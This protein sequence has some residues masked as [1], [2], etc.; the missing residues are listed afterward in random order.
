[1]N[2]KRVLTGCLLLGLG[3]AVRAGA[4]TFTLQ[5]AAD[6]SLRVGSANQNHGSDPTLQLSHDGRVLVRFDQGALA[7]TVG[8]G[9]LVSASLE[10][11]VQS[12]SGWGAAGHPIE[13][14][15]LTA[16]WTEAGATWNCA[17]DAN[18]AN[19]K[20]DCAAPW[21]GGTF[22]D[23]ASDT[24]LQTKDTGVWLIFD[25]TADVAA[26]LAGTPNQGWLIE[27]SDG[28][29]SGKAE[30]TS[31]E[32]AAAERPRLVLLVET[33]AND[34]VPPSLA[35][36][37]PNQPVL[38][39]DP[40]P[41]IALAYADGGSGIDLATLQV[42][43]DGQDVTAACVVGPQS[44]TCHAAPIL[45]A[46]N[47]AVQA[48]LRDRAGNAAQASAAFQLLLG[49]GPHVVTLQTVGD[50]DLRGGEADRN[51]GAEPV[52]RVRESGPNRALVQ[53]DASALASTLAGATLVSASLELHIGLN[54]RNWGKTGRPV[55]AHRLTGTW[56]EL[57]ATWDCPND[58]NATNREPDCATPWAGGSFAPA[59][60]ASVLHTR[61]LTGWVTFDVTAD[62]AAF[63]A[64]G[65]DFGWLLKKTDETQ[66]GRVDYDSRE[67]T[68]GDATR[69]V[70]VFTTSS[71]A[72]D[73]TPPAA[74]ITSPGD[75]ALVSSPTVTVTGSASDNVGLASLTVNGLPVTVTNGGFQT[76][77]DLAE[78][79]NTIFAIATD[80]SGLQSTATVAVT[81]DSTPPTLTVDSPRPNQPTNQAMIEVA[82]SATD[83]SGI[84]AVSVNGTPVSLVGDRFDVPVILAEGANTLTVAATDG[85]GNR[86]QAAVVAT[87]FS[88]P[89]VTI[90]SPADLSYLA[91]TTVDVSGTVSDPGAVVTVEGV[92]ATVSGTSF[93]ARD[94][95][96]V[97]GGNTVTAAATNS[98][99]HTA[100]ATINVVRDLTPPYVV[101]Y[102]PQDGST[103]SQPAVAVSGLI[104]DIVPGTVN[105]GQAAVEVN[106]APAAV[107]N[108][109]FL[110]PSLILT[111]GVNVITAVGTDA[112]G[113]QNQAQVTVNYQPPIGPQLR[114]TAGD[115]QTGTIG[116]TLPKALIVTAVDGAGY[117]VTDHAII[118]KV[119]GNDGTLDGGKR[120][121]LISTDATGLAAV[122]FTLG[123]RAGVGNQ[124][125]EASAAGFAGPAIFHL[126]ATPG[127]TALVVVDAGD[128]QVGV[129]GQHLPRPLIVAVVDAG[130]NRLAGV[131]VTFQVVKGT[132]SFDNGQPTLSLATDSDGRAITAFTTG[133]D[134]GIS[135]N[136]VTARVDGLASGN[137]VAFT[138]SGWVAEDVSQTAISGLV[139]DNANQPVPGVTL[140]IRDTAITTQA[141]S[142]GLFRIF[143][144][145]VGTVK[146][147]VD[148]STARRQGSWPDLEYEVTTVPGRDNKLGMPVYLL[149]LD[150]T[151]GVLIDETHGGT[152]TL[153]DVPGF[154]L[155][156]QPGSITFPGGSRSGVVSATVVHGDKVPMVPNFG[157]QPRLILTI[158]PPGARFDPPARM[159]LPNVEGL[160]PGQVTEMY[161]FDHDLGH[162]VSIG[163]ATVSADG[164][165]VTS[166]LGVGVIK[167][168]WHCCGNPAGTGTPNHCDDCLK[169]DGN[170]CIPDSKALCQSCSTGKVCDGE[171]RCQEGRLLIPK[172]C[173]QIRLS[174]A[175]TPFFCPAG[176]CGAGI[177]RTISK[178][179]H[180]CDHADLKNAILKEVVSEVSA[181]CLPTSFQTGKGC[182]V[183]P[184][185][186]FLDCSDHITMCVAPEL[187][188]DGECRQVYKQEIYLDKCL[189]ET[190]TITF[191]I[192][193][194]STSCSG[195]PD[196]A[197]GK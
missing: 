176:R 57:G 90:T 58:S 50:T 178:V 24:I 49:P 147:I 153:A 151:E 186:S 125:V 74:A 62:V 197:G 84:G 107:A 44:A 177:D 14:H 165:A 196:F 68:A 12:A 89:A 118:F 80:T 109:S 185:N 66:S 64:G 1:V 39:N 187:L 5:A 23:D 135:N 120:E 45:A 119:K 21:A 143:P 47:H 30:Y 137:S 183:A 126:S 101:I 60:T 43:V 51:T 174:D 16:A 108:R 93:T 162:F 18:P 99:G 9:R 72:S 154:T 163:P 2:G 19:N 78:G 29:Q 121:L 85:A 194:T 173:D 27:K 169:C 192:A 98:L 17:V 33:A 127:P 97:E 171:G 79:S 132:G 69:L 61:D 95:P 112:S 105:Q 102:S 160:A 128:Q 53:F 25:V 38:V 113:N 164:S 166:N 181:G 195:S 35:I 6:T 28:D 142:Q 7:S 144:A 116:T 110:L 150:E 159:T 96:L 157:Q 155:E 115:Q 4:Q 63:A 104:N 130:S 158:Q 191:T 170:N 88:L 100:T 152:L 188:K 180:D 77:V 81:L 172:I 146:L 15:P 3:F 122:H 86:S 161:S 156:I 193:K 106:G 34:Q 138:A 136:I 134:D 129:A 167:A 190:N 26:F 65:P 111:P 87:R 141:D 117:P 168:G 94:V 139:V 48:L 36:T 52:L 82:G 149:P 42:L 70:L 13:A 37:S 145:P 10:L 123:G 148:G 182:I 133:P 40:A 55:E 75:G 131:P 20:Q 83:A 59:P 11:F 8:A 179:V 32:G 103:V 46:G 175:K 71:G 41:T 140:R 91:A 124:T 114:I 56:T 184:G 67:G 31:R 54:G 73:T 22:A 76:T 189:V 92:T